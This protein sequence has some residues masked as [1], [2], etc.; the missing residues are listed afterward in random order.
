MNDRNIF[1]INL[2]IDN[3]GYTNEHFEKNF[4]INSAKRRIVAEFNQILLD[5]LENGGLSIT[6]TDSYRGE[7]TLISA[8][9]FIATEREMRDSGRYVEINTTIKSFDEA[10]YE[11]LKDVEAKNEDNYNIDEYLRKKAKG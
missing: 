10:D 11:R 4:K 7:T 1:Q 2:E 6:K 5:K 3:R 9:L 8:K